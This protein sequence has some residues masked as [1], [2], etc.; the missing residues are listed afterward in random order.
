MMT[1]KFF[2]ADTKITIEGKKC[3]RSMGVDSLAS[4]IE[5]SGSCSGSSCERLIIL[6]G[7]QFDDK[8][9]QSDYLLLHPN[10]YYVNFRTCHPLQL[11]V[12]IEPCSSYV[13]FTRWGSSLPYKEILE[14]AWLLRIITS[15]EVLGISVFEQHGNAN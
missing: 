11:E 6:H 15:K 3:E 13:G 7:S 5:V 1:Y 14:Y 10:S 9:A 4:H 12:N 8:V 2:F